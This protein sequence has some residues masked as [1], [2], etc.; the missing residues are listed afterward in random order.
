MIWRVMESLP[1][2]Q[3]ISFE[4]GVSMYLGS[5]YY[6][7]CIIYSELARSVQKFLN[8][9]VAFLSFQSLGR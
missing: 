5:R 7:C 2:G 6:L 1:A 9:I 3:L 4:S 8:R